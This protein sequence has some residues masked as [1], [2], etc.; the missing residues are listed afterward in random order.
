MDILRK[1]LS[2]KKTINEKDEG[3]PRLFLYHASKL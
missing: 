2:Q 1:V 3:R